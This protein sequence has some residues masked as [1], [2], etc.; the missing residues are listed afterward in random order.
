[1]I[2]LVKASCKSQKKR[3]LL[4]QKEWITLRETQITE[5]NKEDLV[6]LE[7]VDIDQTLPHEDRLTSFIEQIKNPYCFVVDGTIVKVTFSNSQESFTDRATVF[8][9]TM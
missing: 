2:I 9:N 3:D 1:M 4:T 8:L 6:S 5:V 7:D